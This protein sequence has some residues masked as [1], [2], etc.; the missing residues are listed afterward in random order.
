MPPGVEHRHIP[1]ALHHP[2]IEDGLD[3]DEAGDLLR[4]GRAEYLRRTVQ[5]EQPAVHQDPD[6]VAERHGLTAIVGDEDRR[7]PLLAQDAPE[8]VDQALPRRGIER[9]ERLV[10]QQDLRLHHE[11]PR[12]RRALR[13]TAR[14]RARPA[15]GEVRDAEAPEPLSH[16]A[17]RAQAALA[18]K[19]QAQ[20][21]V[22]PD[23]RVGEERFLKDTRHAPPDCQR[24]ARS[25]GGAAEAHLTRHGGFEQTE[26]T[27]ERRLARAVRA[28]EG[29]DLARQHRERGHVEHGAAAVRYADPQELEHGRRHDGSTWID[30]R[31]TESSQWRSRA[32]SRISYTMRGTSI[33]RSKSP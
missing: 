25:D 18:A 33:S 28:D 26:D 27:Q 23:R 1:S 30:P 4:G 6:A 2:A 7:G 14:D 3:A 15:L 17:R 16:P 12:Q 10:E 29:E 19:A 11:G 13:L 9:G 32:M 5:L 8:I 20:G 22:L 21:H 31:C 24:G